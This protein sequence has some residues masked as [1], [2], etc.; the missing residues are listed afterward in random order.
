VRGVYGSH[1]PSNGRSL[2]A[3]H[4]IISNSVF[5]IE[6]A[7]TLPP[8][9]RLVGVPLPLVSEPIGS[10]LQDWLDSSARNNKSVVVVYLGDAHVV[11][12]WQAQALVY[13]Y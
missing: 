9:Y 7:R 8:R 5:G 3:G 6:Y 4:I 13:Y 12:K 11:E 10:R 1:P 2:H